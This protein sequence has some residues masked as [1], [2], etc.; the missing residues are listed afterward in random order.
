MPPPGMPP[1]AVPP[2]GV[3]LPCV[4]PPVPPLPVKPP[5]GVV[6]P[7]TAASRSDSPP[8]V[9]A[10]QPSAPASTTTPKT[11]VRLIMR[12]LVQ[13]PDQHELADLL[14]KR[15]AELCQSAQRRRR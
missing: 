6:P 11:Q 10:A 8:T 14:G 12:L 3:L 4:L 13:R 5:T 15:C 1:P 2:P 9:R 7:P